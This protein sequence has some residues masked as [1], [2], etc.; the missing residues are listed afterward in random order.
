[1]VCTWLAISRGHSPHRSPEYWYSRRRRVGREREAPRGASCDG[2]RV[3]CDGLRF[4]WTTRSHQQLSG[5]HGASATIAYQRNSGAGAMRQRAGRAL[6]SAGGGPYASGA[7]GFCFGG[8]M[9][10]ELALTGV[11]LKAVVGFHSGLNVTSPGDAKQIRAKVLALLGADDPSITVED[12]NKFENMLRE[13]NVDWQITYYGGVVHAFTNEHAD[14]LA[15]PAFAD[16]IPRPMP[17]RG[18]RCPSCSA[19]SSRERRWGDHA[20][21]VQCP[22]PV[23]GATRPV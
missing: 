22:H 13:A 3:C 23:A 7:I 1:M 19:R 5:G 17:V 9:T 4:V 16:T 21:S 15:R 6:G 12:R 18:S 2:V 14:R 8:T 10:Y 11:D 20:C